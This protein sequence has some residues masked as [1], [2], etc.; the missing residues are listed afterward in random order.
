M[1]IFDIDEII[2][3][4]WFGLRDTEAYAYYVLEEVQRLYDG[5]ELE[6]DTR[7]FIDELFD[8]TPQPNFIFDGRKFNYMYCGNVILVSCEEWEIDKTFYIINGKLC[9][10]TNR[11]RVNIQQHKNK[12]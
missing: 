12:S 1:S 4:P 2:N 5:G 11:R 3:D 9:L 8:P 6:E 7:D 10:I